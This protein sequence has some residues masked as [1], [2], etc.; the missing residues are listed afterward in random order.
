MSKLLFRLH[1]K[2]NRNKSNKG[3]EEKLTDIKK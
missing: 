2:P 3:N 1:K